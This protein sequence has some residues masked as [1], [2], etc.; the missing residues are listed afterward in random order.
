[1]KKVLGLILLGNLFLFFSCAKE[2]EEAIL[3]NYRYCTDT[4][5]SFQNNIQPILNNDCVSCHSG[6]NADGNV[7]LD[8]YNDVKI[9]MLNGSLMGTV[10]HSP[11]FIAMP[12]GEEKWNECKLTTFQ[13]W[14]DEGTQN[15]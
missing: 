1:M 13:I 3:D 8:N 7:R 9:Y 12:L 6:S 14:K 15:N 11:G 5:V 2:S 10:N 4:L